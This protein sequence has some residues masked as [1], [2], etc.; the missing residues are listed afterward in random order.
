[1]VSDTTNSVIE[2][3]ISRT[4]QANDPAEVLLKRISVAS[5]QAAEHRNATLD[6]IPRKK[7]IN[8]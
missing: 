8:T 5:L 2:Q 6:I 4:F 7:Q 3:A 1:M